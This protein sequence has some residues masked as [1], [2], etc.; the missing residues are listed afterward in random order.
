MNE[1]VI[2][3]A[4][5]FGGAVSG[6]AW[7]YFL[8]KMVE[9]RRWVAEVTPSLEALE[10]WAAK[11][12]QE[13]EGLEL[14]LTRMGSVYLSDTLVRNPAEATDVLAEAKGRLLSITPADGLDLKRALSR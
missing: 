9:R 1:I 12:C 8:G 14:S 5:V 4:L 2:R 3:E 6:A 7:G 10:R 13:L 11:V